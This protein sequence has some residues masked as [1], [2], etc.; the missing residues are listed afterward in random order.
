M[1]NDPLVDG[2]ERQADF[3]AEIQAEADSGLPQLC[4]CDFP[5]GSATVAQREKMEGH[6][7]EVGGFCCPHHGNTCG[8][9]HKYN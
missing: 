7:N 1:F 8:Y 5:N 6:Y 4:V 9:C 3:E 2:Q